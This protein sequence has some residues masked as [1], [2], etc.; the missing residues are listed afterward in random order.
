MSDA[1]VIVEPWPIYSDDGRAPFWNV[2]VTS[3]K[4]SV[5]LQWSCRLGCFRRSES[6]MRLRRGEPSSHR[7]AAQFMRGFCASMW[8]INRDTK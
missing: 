8:S 1:L 7:A 2:R 3:P 4:R 6:L 5:A